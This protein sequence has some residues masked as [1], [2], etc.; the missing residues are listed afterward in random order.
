MLYPEIIQK[1]ANFF[2]KDRDIL[3]EQSTSQIT[4][5]N[6]HEKYYFLAVQINNT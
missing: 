5:K 1:L 3:I 4:E 2:A 6:L